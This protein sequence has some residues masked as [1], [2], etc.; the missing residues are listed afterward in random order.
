ML[1]SET[2]TSGLFFDL[3][4]GIVLLPLIGLLINIIIGHKLGEKGVGAVAAS[5]SGLAFVVALLQ[6]YSLSVHHEGAM[7]KVAD[8][9]HIGNLALEVGDYHPEARQRIAENFDGWVGWI[10]AT[11]KPGPTAPATTPGRTAPS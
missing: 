3:V 9:I 10:I 1:F 7:V 11:R 4:P 2:A 8:W 5:A 6:V